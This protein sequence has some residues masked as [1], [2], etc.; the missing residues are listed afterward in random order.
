MLCPSCEKSETQVTDSR[1]AGQA[2]RRRRECLD[3]GFRFTTFERM[4]MRRLTVI[5]KDGRR[6]PFDRTKLITGLTKACEK[7]PISKE[8]IENTVGDIE[9]MLAEELQ[10][11]IPSQKIGEIVMDKLRDLDGIAYIRFASVYRSFDNLS[12]F[13][14]ALHQLK[15][16]NQ[17]EDPHAKPRRKDGNRVSS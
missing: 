8:L 9:K 3:C 6:E 11:E 15:V 10:A 17:K 2:V 1:D 13:E 5:K 4:E 14:N 7:R 16:A 12:S